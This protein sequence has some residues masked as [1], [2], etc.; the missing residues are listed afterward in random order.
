LKIFQTVELSR[1][2]SKVRDFHSRE[3]LGCDLLS[4]DIVCPCV[5]TI[6]PDSECGRFLQNVGTLKMETAGSF[7]ML[8]TTYEATQWHNPE[9]QKPGKD[10]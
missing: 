5:V 2:I 7:K 1:Q 4:F 8:L 6:D 9:N 10:Y 3:N